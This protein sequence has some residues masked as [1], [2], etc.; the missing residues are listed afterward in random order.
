M[1]AVIG[2][3]M[4]TNDD[5]LRLSADNPGWRFERDDDGALLVSP[6]TSTWG[7]FQSGTA[8]MQLAAYA[9]RVGG[10]VAD[11]SGG[12]ETQ[13]HAVFSPDAMWFSA[14]KIESIRLG[15]TFTNMIPDV[16]VE[17]ASGSD[18]H[19][20]V[21]EKIDRYAGYGIPYAVAFFPS[22]GGVYER[23]TPPPGLAFDVAAICEH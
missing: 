16:V 13:T 21:R 22:D 4:V 12:F 1:H 11:S 8:F 3:L 9:Q 5:L 14:E 10:R 15:A 17:V 20:Q 2:G 18:S 19:A 6:P 23:G 7:G